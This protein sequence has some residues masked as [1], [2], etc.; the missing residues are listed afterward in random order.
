[1]AV[2]LGGARAI[3]ALTA[4]PGRLALPEQREST[5]THR[6]RD[7]T[8]GPACERRL[9][10]EGSGSIPEVFALRLRPGP[11]QSHGLDTGKIIETAKN[12]ADEVTIV[13][14]RIPTRCA[15]LLGRE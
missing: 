14:R 13:L 11:N 9:D 1:M 5:P 3:E 4:N 8:A 6:R 15:H 7:F 12:I 2:V 10:R